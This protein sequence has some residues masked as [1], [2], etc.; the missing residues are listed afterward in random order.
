MA[1]LGADEFVVILAEV[2]EIGDV[3]LLARKIIESLGVPYELE[4]GGIHLTT[5]KPVP[6]DEFK[7]ML[8]KGLTLTRTY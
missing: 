6:A 8:R 7:S 2:A 3:G 4:N 1:R 5:S